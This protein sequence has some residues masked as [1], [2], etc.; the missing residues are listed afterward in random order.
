MSDCRMEIMDAV[1]VQYEASIF[2]RLFLAPESA[3]AVLSIRFASDDEER[4]RE[5]MDKNNRGTLSP[6]EA[7]EMEAFRRIGAFLAI[8]QAKARLALQDGNE[9]SAT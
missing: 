6:E 1:A 2:E 7:A 8:A 9:P 3:R 5:L 4:M